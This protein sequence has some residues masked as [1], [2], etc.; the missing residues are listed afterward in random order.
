MAKTPPERNIRRQLRMKAI[1]IPPTATVPGQFLSS[2][3]VV[4]RPA[5]NALDFY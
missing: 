5:A 2:R 3:I 1:R 4:K